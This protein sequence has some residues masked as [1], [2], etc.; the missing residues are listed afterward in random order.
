MARPGISK[1]DVQAARLA[2]MKAGNHP[3][4][5]AIRIQ[6]GNTGSKSTI[7][8]LVKEIE[9]DEGG[10][11]A[12]LPQ[13][14]LS[15][16]LQAFVAHLAARMELESQERFDALQ[17]SHAAEGRRLT[18]VRD[19][20]LA[21]SQASLRQAEQQQILAAE[22]QAARLRSEDEL[23]ALRLAHAQLEGHLTAQVTALQ[24]Q[25]DT[26]QAHAAAL[27]K[28]HDHA[29]QALEHFRAASKE[30]RDREARQHEQQ[31]QYL[32]REVANAAEALTTKQTEL[33]TAL[34]EKADA[35]ALL[36]AARAERRQVDEQ[37]RELRPAAE[38]LAVQNQLLEDL[39]QQAQLATQQYE[40]LR[41]RAKELEQRNGELERLLAAANA[42][43][44]SQSGFVKE[45]LERIGKSAAPGTAKRKAAAAG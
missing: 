30:Q 31:I 1:R 26:A 40:T 36:T 21:E 29:H 43:A 19:K 5:D 22:S 13:T 8:R 39:R 15:E 34:Q 23:Q 20:A 17:E 12:S 25:L 14:T 3:S 18:E 9:D 27:E 45:V 37:L 4:I 32:Q 11:G 42:A 41:A 7:S 28:Q 44:Q 24:Q 33:R 35:L 16:Q 2:V 38:R 6:L 10:P